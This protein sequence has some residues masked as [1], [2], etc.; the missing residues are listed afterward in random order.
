MQNIPVVFCINRHYITQ[1]AVLC[2]SIIISSSSHFDFYILSKDLKSVDINIL[3]EFVQKIDSASRIN[4]IDMQTSIVHDLD[5]FMSSST[6]YNYISSETFF[7]FYIPKV[8]NL[9]KVIYLDA[10]TLVL[11]DLSELFDI[12]LGRL[13]AGVVKDPLIQRLGTTKSEPMMRSRPSM[14]LNEYLKKILNTSYTNYF[15]AGVMIL[16]L[17]Q[18][19][20]DRIDEK[21]WDFT[22][23]HSPLDY[24]DQDVLN[25]V[26]AEHVKYIHP[27]WNVTR[28]LEDF[29]AITPN[30]IS[31][32]ALQN[33]AIIHYNGKIKPWNIEDRTYNFV[34]TW[35]D[36]FINTSLASESDI[37]NYKRILNLE[38]LRNYKR[39]LL[40]KVKKFEL[41]HIYRQN[42]R[43]WIFFFGKTIAHLQ[44][45][46]IYNINTSNF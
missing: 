19:R 38:S 46:K 26:F 43:Y 42:Y 2:R 25:S 12:N 31:I 18:L 16:N 27:K 39:I 15:N 35:W 9:D 10:D 4:Y 24:Q 13:Y 7:R 34:L 17:K 44:A 33:P 23:R 8:I 3:T 11:K 30:Q 32:T 29:N 5:A 36:F 37:K 41:I 28:D 1:L 22:K 20:H 6:N 40:I 14:N 21:L 45:N